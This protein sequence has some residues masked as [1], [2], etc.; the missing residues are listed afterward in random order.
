V[1]GAKRY[2]TVQDILGMPKLSDQSHRVTP[3]IHYGREYPTNPWDIGHMLWLNAKDIV[4]SG[5]VPFPTHQSINQYF[6]K[7]RAVIAERWNRVKKCQE[8]KRVEWTLKKEHPHEWMKRHR[9]GDFKC[10]PNES[11]F[12]RTQY[13]YVDYIPGPIPLIFENCTNP[14]PPCFDLACLPRSLL[15]AFVNVITLY[16]GIINGV[17]QYNPLFQLPVPT[18]SE[19]PYFTG[20]LCRA[21]WSTRCFQ[22]DILNAATNVLRVPYCLCNMITLLIPITLTGRQQPRICEVIVAG[23]DFIAS[24]VQVIVNTV[25]CLVL[26]GTDEP[27]HYAYFA[28][29]F[30]D[31]DINQQ[32]NYALAVV[33]RIADLVRDFFPF[34]N[35]ANF[36]PGCLVEVL[37]NIY[38]D[39]SRHYHYW[40][41]FGYNDSWDSP[42]KHWLA[43]S[44]LVSIGHRSRLSWH[45][46]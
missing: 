15:L 31:S 23:A 10:D 3:L 27:Q 29:G 12:E 39:S 25:M 19:F 4:G 40:C 5:V 2:D 41:F 22:T 43:G 18:V 45:S 44:V 33:A 32:A 20:E 13:E 17:F 30:F 8:A 11:L 9:N 36:D 46:G 21:P 16:G 42:T 35:Q 7:K 34:I 26:G 24:G 28:G 37:A 1:G 6:D 14:T 38:R